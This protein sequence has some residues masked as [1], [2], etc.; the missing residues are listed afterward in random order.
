MIRQK[1]LEKIKRVKE[2]VEN[3]T[4]LTVALRGA[5]LT[6]NTYYKYAK[7]HYDLSKI[8][9]KTTD[10]IAGEI[11]LNQLSPPADRTDEQIEIDRLRRVLNEQQ[12]L[13][14]HYQQLNQSMFDIFAFYH[15]S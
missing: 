5:K 3:G 7:P 4:A 6:R 8:K 15:Q 9:Q 12:Q 1:T 10:A 11:K 13:I 14:V 2:L